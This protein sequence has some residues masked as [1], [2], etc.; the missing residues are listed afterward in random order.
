[1]DP[2][3]FSGHSLR[4]GFVT[5]AA[6]AGHGELLIADQT[7]HK[8]VNIVRGYVREANAFR[9]NAGKGLLSGEA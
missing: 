5:S 4:A 1:L 9:K 7:R 8:N 6:R 2:A 3:R